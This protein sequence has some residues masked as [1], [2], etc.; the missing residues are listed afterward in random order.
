MTDKKRRTVSLDEPIDRELRSEDVNAS[1]LINRLL[2]EY[3]S[4]GL[5]EEAALRVKL[6][7]L[8]QERQRYQSKRELA[9]SQIQKIEDEIDLIKDEL[10]NLDQQEVEQVE[11]VVNLVLADKG[12]IDQDQLTTDNELVKHRAGKAGMTPDRFVREVNERL[13]NAHA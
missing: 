12:G 9:N 6:N 4:S 2:D 11:T 8:Q 13:D 3:Y 5:A 7:D 1:G 10:N